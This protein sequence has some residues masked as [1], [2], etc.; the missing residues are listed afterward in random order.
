MND[1]FCPRDEMEARLVVRLETATAEIRPQEAFADRLEADLL[2]RWARLAVALRPR[3]A[4]SG[5]VWL[6]TRHRWA[7]IGASLLFAVAVI[8]VILG[9]QRVWADLLN[10]LGYVPGVGFVDLD[11][12]R[13]LVAPVEVTRDGVT[14]RVE[15]VLAGPDKTI[16]VIDSQGLPPEDRFQTQRILD[17]TEFEP[18]LRL[19]DGST[20]WPKEWDVLRGKGTIRFPPLSEDVYRVTLNLPRLPLVESGKAPEDWSIPLALRPATGELVAE[21]FPQPY[22]PT[23]AVDTHEDITLRV[24]AVAQTP[25]ETVLQVQVQWPD[26]AWRFPHIGI[27]YYWVP[28]LEDD[29]GHV[30][31]EGPPPG[32]G[33]E[34]GRV[35]EQI[36]VDRDAT[37]T[38]APVVPTYEEAMSFAPVSFSATRLTLWVDDVEF[39][40]PVEGEF[41]VD[42]GEDP[43]VGDYWP[44]DVHLTAAGF[45]VHVTGARLVEEWMPDRN[46]TVLE[47]QLQFEIE[48]VP[49]QGNRELRSICLDGS[50]AGFSG[51]G[52]GV[53]GTDR[54]PHLDIREGQLIPTGHVQ[55]QVK[56][57]DVLSRGPW[58]LDW[59]VPGAGETGAV[60][61][62]LRPEHAA[63]TRSSVT[64]CVDEVVQTDRLTAVTIEGDISL[65]GATP[66]WDAPMWG[67]PSLTLWWNPALRDPEGRR[68]EARYLYDE[69]NHRY[70]STRGTTWQPLPGSDERSVESATPKVVLETLF[71]EPL[72]PFVRRTTLRVPAVAVTL[73]G[74]AAFEVDVP[75]G[76][77]VHPTPDIPERVSDPWPVDIPVEIAGYRL[78]FAEARLQELDGRARLVLT[79]DAVEEGRDSQWLAGMGLAA[80]TGPNG[81]TV[82]LSR[83]YATAGP[84]WQGDG[85]YR[86]WAAFDVS[87]PATGALQPGRY[88]VELD[89]VFVAVQGP[90][91]LTWRLRT[92]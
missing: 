42:L 86:V 25:E 9:P 54:L 69:R 67:M 31:H 15:Q 73:P 53:G 40:V 46:R 65:P 57:A 59:T 20:L 78:R 33:S 8:L 85:K 80:V 29:L 90:W 34:A 2:A 27:G 72:Q 16:V 81:Q 19:P 87:D 17:E 56:D 22:A 12:T 47:R 35:V 51:A 92:P 64:L 11:E 26:P 77:A 45:P 13:V 24:L 21:L 18:T 36:R 84:D 50:I 55:V 32:V 63:E 60:P 23:D 14:L 83:A 76:V 70:E 91:E 74:V 62:T 44:L 89:G 49:G 61:V 37:P 68:V 39:T 58:R 1:S 82:D 3:E 38:P 79:S 75:A 88:H 48:P 43:Q 4:V 71:F 41:S 5:P 52:C 30:Y 66:G 6:F 28:R 7:A 10:L